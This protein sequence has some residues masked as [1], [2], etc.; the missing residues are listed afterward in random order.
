MRFLFIVLLAFTLIRI[1]TSC[2]RNGQTE[3]TEA[4]AYEEKAENHVAGNATAQPVDAPAAEPD[5]KSMGRDLKPRQYPRIK[6]KQVQAKGNEYLTVF[7]LPTTYLFIEEKNEISLKAKQDLKGIAD[8]I[9]ESYPQGRVYVYNHAKG[10]AGGSA[11]TGTNGGK[12]TQVKRWLVVQE[13]LDEA[14][15]FVPSDSQSLPHAPD[16]PGG[17]P[18]TVQIVAVQL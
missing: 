14:R 1:G 12:A 4:A 7:T 6:S 10:R 18:G 13:H 11:A 5:W 16:L 17:T 8:V 3:S 2:D 15:I 9:K